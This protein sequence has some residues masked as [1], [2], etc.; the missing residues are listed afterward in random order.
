MKRYITKAIRKTNQL[1]KFS[2]LTFLFCNLF[3]SS[4]SQFW[5]Q[6]GNGVNNNVFAFAKDT[7]NNVLYVGG[8][9][10]DVSGTTAFRVAKWDGASWSTVGNGFD[11]DV[12]SLYYDYTSNSLYAGG[13]FATSGIT[14]INKIA[15][16]NGTSWSALGTGCDASVLALT[17]DASGNIY[18]GGSFTTAGGISAQSIAKWNGSSWSAMGAGLGTSGN[19]VEALTVFQ[20]QVYA[21]GQYPASGATALNSIARWDGVQWNSLN[22]GLT[23]LSQRASAFK[24][25]NGELIVGGTYTAAGGVAANSLAKWNGTTWVA[26]PGGITGGQAKIKALGYLFNTLYVGGNFNNA[27]AVTAIDIAAYDGTNWSGLGAGINGQVDALMDY[28]QE[29]YTGGA[30]T[31]VDTISATFIARYRTTCLTVASVSSTPNSCFNSCNGQAVVSAT[32]LTPFSYQWSTSPVQTN[33]TATGLCAGTYSVIIT[34]AA[35]CSITDSVTVTQPAQLAVNFSSNNPGC[36]GQCTGAITAANN[37]Q[38]TVTYSWNTNPVQTTLQAINLCAGTYTVQITDSA[39]CALTDSLTLTDPGANVLTLTSTQPNCTNGCNGTATA[40]STGTP[41]F[42]YAWNTSPVQ[43]TST[44]GNLCPGFYTV[45]VTDSL[46]CSATDS[47]EVLNPALT[48]LQF[49]TTTNSCFASCNGSAVVTATGVAPFTYSWSTIPVQTTDTA[50]TLC[51]GSYNVVVTDSLGCS[52]TDSIT[53]TEPAQL[54]IV[55]SKTDATCFGLCNGTAV[56]ANNG[57]GALTYL[58]NTSPV[59]TT[60]TATGLCAGTYSVM[61]IDSAGCAL[62]DSVT[63]N[64]PVANQLSSTSIAPTCNNGCNGT[65]TS[66]STGIAPFSYSWNTLPVQITDTATNLCPGFYVVTVTDSIG[67]SA[68]DSVEVLNPSA[69]TLQFS[70][71]QPV[72]FGGCDGSASVVSSGPA[73]YVYLWSAASQTNDTA[74]ALCAGIYLVIITDSLGC[75]VTDSVN[76]TQPIQN[77]LTVTQQNS[78]CAIACNGNAAVISTGQIP[79]NYV[80]STTDT[81]S[82]IDSLC[83]GNFAITVTDGLGCVVSDSVFILNNAPLPI[84]FSTQ[85]SA[86]NGNCTGAATASISGLNNLTYLWSTGD[87]VATIDTLCPATFAVTITDELGCISNDSVAIINLPVFTNT[88]TLQPTCF[89]QCNA[90]ISINPVGTAPFQLLWSTG[91]TTSYLI[92]SLCSGNYSISITDSVGCVGVDSITITD[93]ADIIYS[94]SHADALCAGTCTGASTLTASGNGPLVYLWNTV[95]TQSDTTVTNLCFGYTLFTITDSSGC[96]KQDSVLIFEP[97]PIAFNPNFLGITCSGNCDGFV[98]VNPI[99]GTPNYTYEWSN[100][101]TSNTLLNVCA[102]VYTLTI[103]DFN[104]CVDSTTYTFTDPDPISISFTVTDATCAGCTNGS[105]V[106]SISGGTAP[107]DPL[108]PAL[109]IADTIATNLGTGY[110]LFCA[111]DFNGCLQ[112]DSVFVDE[113]TSIQNITASKS[114]IKIYPNPF[115]RDA[116]IKI[117]NVDNENYS[118]EFYDV[119]GRKISMQ[120]NKSS[121][122]EKNLYYRIH[123]DNLKPGMYYV[124]IISGDEVQ[125]V[126]KF[127]IR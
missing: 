121:R 49:S 114:E 101:F 59:Q 57:Q 41:S 72:C 87:T 40:I 63:I 58:W 51:A 125:G 83:A 8:R 14:P 124:K 110:Y 5:L 81:T 1:T 24:I 80:W 29:M 37:G 22:G 104:L 65:A 111:Q 86:C 107:Y 10:N 44:A 39:G 68:T 62:M 2:L 95:P 23:G 26:Y 21:G 25:V 61:I 52:V 30:F 16:W 73:P 7:V 77:V 18:A 67:C 34:D 75:S 53:I 20:G 31:I 118:I 89:G 102:G 79:F 54:A 32:G 66:L 100:G 117:S 103:T 42:T 28:K 96:F 123:N 71:T 13:A 74:T 122:S 115:T 76:V 84:L 4:H 108:F 88:T 6:V 113:G 60:D 116:V 35:G 109:S 91:D 45:T 105:I 55:F 36:S 15:K 12:N 127:I 19:Y 93:P 27:G 3:F 94:A 33:D 70:F 119:S 97:S 120:N 50:T 48:T 90:T 9:F 46:G 82:S 85:Y 56:A 43:T 92:D 98:Q 47:V 99:G 17:G 38:G 64:E 69:A 106:A 78:R 11:S 126:G 112:C